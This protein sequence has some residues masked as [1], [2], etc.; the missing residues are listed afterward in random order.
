MQRSLEV[1]LGW[2]G[3]KADLMGAFSRAGEPEMEIKS[4]TREG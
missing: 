2:K 4:N 3:T 1:F